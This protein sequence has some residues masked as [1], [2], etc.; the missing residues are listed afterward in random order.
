MLKKYRT[1]KD[2]LLW[3]ATMGKYNESILTFLVLQAIFLLG[4][5]N[6]IG[7]SEY[8]IFAKRIF[9]QTWNH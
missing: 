2:I 7:Y 4:W 9:Q 8:P 3:K 6:V 5:K 1:Q